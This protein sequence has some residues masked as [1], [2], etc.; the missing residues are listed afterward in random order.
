[1]DEVDFFNHQVI[2]NL[3]HA[4]FDKARIYLVRLERYANLLPSVNVL[5]TGRHLRNAQK[6]WQVTEQPLKLQ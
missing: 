6:Y 2:Q 5:G 1:M 3:R 4:C